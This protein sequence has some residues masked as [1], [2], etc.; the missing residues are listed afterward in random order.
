MDAVARTQRPA[1]GCA[2]WPIDWPAKQDRPG[3]DARWA[4]LQAFWD[5]HATSTL[6]NDVL[7]RLERRDPNW[8]EVNRLLHARD[9]LARWIQ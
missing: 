2:G 6:L 9:G 8:S 7:T 3:D 5:R 1:Q 4:N